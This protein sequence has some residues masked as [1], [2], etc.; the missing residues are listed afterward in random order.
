MVL[1]IYKN[2]LLRPFSVFFLGNYSKELNGGTTEL[3]RAVGGSVELLVKIILVSLVKI[4]FPCQISIY[5]CT[6]WVI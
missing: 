6:H 5:L 3:L 1:P 2:D 4:L